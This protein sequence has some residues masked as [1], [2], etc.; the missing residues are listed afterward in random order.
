MPARNTA[1]VDELRAG[2]QRVLQLPRGPLD[3][4]SAGLLETPGRERAY[5][6]LA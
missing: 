4:L 3:A 1:S 2:M 6:R 5:R